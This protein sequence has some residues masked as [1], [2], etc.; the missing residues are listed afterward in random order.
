MKTLIRPFGFS[1]FASLAVAAVAVYYVGVSALWPLLVLS[2]IEIT[3]SFDN[4]VVNAKV[5]KK[6][7]PLWQKVFL[8]VGIIIAIFGMRLVFP[9]LLVALTAGLPWREVI[10]LALHH[11]NEYAHH[12]EA[13]HPVITA[14]GGAF[15]L[16]LAL[17]FFADGSKKHHWIGRFEHGLSR[18]GHWWFP[19][20]ITAAVLIGLSVLPANHHPADTMKAGLIGLLTYGVIH[21]MTSLLGVTTKSTAKQTHFGGWTAFLMFIYLEILDASFSLDGVLGAFAITNNVLLIMAGLGIGAVWVRSLTVFMVRRGTLDAYR[22]LEHGAH[23]AIAV[24][25]LAMLAG[26]IFEVPE[27]VTGGLGLACIIAAL[28]ASVR[29]NKQSP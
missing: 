3:F 28:T 18:I 4:A 5:L 12:L 25:A 8:S 7:S 10:D 24:L 2:V 27:A 11:P 23:Y 20:V 19:S 9:V 16:M 22:Y 17:H 26:A 1:I 13:A 6:M 15:L 29:A 14:F 21:A